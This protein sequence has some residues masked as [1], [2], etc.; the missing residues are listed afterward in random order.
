MSI[1]ETM[2]EKKFALG[3]FWCPPPCYPQVSNN[4]VLSLT[5]K[6][7]SLKWN[8]T[9]ECER[10]GEGDRKTRESGIHRGKLQ[11]TKN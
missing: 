10:N 6:D 11:I 2:G 8:K 5:C 3:F 1:K 7:H 9:K 4:V